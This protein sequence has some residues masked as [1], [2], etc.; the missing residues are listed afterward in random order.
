MFGDLQ[1]ELQSPS[2]DTAL[3]RGTNWQSGQ[4]LQ[5]TYTNETT[6]T[7]NSLIGEQTAGVWTLRVRDL[8]GYDTGT[9][10]RWAL[11]LTASLGE[12][13]VAPSASLSTSKGPTAVS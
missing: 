6:S 3:L 1:I 11:N 7:L 8:A 9:L 5:A 13:V 12:G 2:G 4:N 10:D